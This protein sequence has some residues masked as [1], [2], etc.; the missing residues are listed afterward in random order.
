MLYFQT[1]ESVLRVNRAVS[2]MNLG[3]KKETLE[4][5]DSE[6]GLGASKT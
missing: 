2:V 6:A 5:T 3:R 4:S 1:Q